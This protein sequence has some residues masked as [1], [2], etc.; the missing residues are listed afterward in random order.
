M[1]E[2]FKKIICNDITIGNGEKNV[3]EFDKTKDSASRPKIRY[4]NENSRFQYTCAVSGDAIYLIGNTN[5]NYNDLTLN[6]DKEFSIIGDGLTSIID[7][8]IGYSNYAFSYSTKP[9]IF[10]RLKV[11]AGQFF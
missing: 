7:Y 2:F 8:G 4:S 3:I 1:V 11:I 5:A 6:L 9:I 10:Y